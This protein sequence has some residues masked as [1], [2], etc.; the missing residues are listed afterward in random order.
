MIVGRT[1]IDGERAVISIADSGPG[2]PV[3]QLRKIFDPF[4]STKEQGMGIGLSIAKSI[5]HAHKGRIWAENQSEGGAVF[6][7]SLP[8]SR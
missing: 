5:V 2:I 8:L 1:A 6:R 3:D 7:I 4:F